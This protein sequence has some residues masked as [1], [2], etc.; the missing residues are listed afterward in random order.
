MT[1]TKLSIALGFLILL[2]AT[3]GS[4]PAQ[5]PEHLA[6]PKAF[7]ALRI[8]STD[9]KFRNADSRPIAPG[10]TL[11]LGRV[12][13]HGQITH[14]WFTIA[15]KSRDHLRELVLRM[16]WDGAEKPAVECPLGDFFGLGFGQA[17]GPAVGAH[18]TSSAPR[19]AGT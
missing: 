16:Y 18:T 12:E 11:E 4:L 17:R 19:P 5:V 6:Q 2:P 14:V 9:P 7:R 10:A 13:G 1:R 8:A 15:G 3:A